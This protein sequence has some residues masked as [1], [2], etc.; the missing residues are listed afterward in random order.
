[1]NGIL[2]PGFNLTL[3]PMAYPKLYEYFIEAQKNTWTVGE[4]SFSTDIGD[5]R[6][7]L[8][9]AEK[10]VVSR[11]VAFFATG[12][13]IVANNA[14]LHLYKHVNSPEAR[15]YYGRQIFEESLH[16]QFYLTLLDNY[17]PNDDER[18]K[19]FDAINNIPS[20]KLKGEFCNKWMSDMEAI[21]ACHTDE[22]KQA[23][24]K[25][26]IAFA[27][28]VEGLFF[29]ASFSYVYF[30]REKGLLNGLADG[31]NWVFR[32]ETMHMQFGYEVIDIIKKQYPE[33]WTEDFQQLI[34]NMID[35]AIE[36]EMQ[37]ADDA[38]SL[39]VAG[40]NAQE[41]RQY[42]EFCA[43]ARLARLG[44][45]RRYGSRNPFS[46]ME[47]QDLDSHGNFFERTISQYQVGAAKGSKEHVAFDEDF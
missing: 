34:Y 13:T 47:L 25:N 30:L 32:D 2:D 42:L 33:L 31:T 29:M 15:L 1:M 26:L 14:V 24:L 3:R 17:L 18:F 41:M 8:T 19:A 21:N 27:A 22:Q 16:V 12:D 45:E 43:D 37:F 39:G 44:L 4:V 35:E 28:C 40:L 6:D 23:F 38:L 10:H 20:I 7:K 5:L 11:L 9:D 46:F 36:C